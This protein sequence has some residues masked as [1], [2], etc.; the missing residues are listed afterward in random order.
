MYWVLQENQ[1]IKERQNQ[2]Q[3]LCYATPE[4]ITTGLILLWLCNIAKLEGP[5]GP[6]K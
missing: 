2:L 4:L 3:D 5:E 1:K 6:S